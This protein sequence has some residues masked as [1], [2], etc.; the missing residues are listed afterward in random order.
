MRDPVFGRVYIVRSTTAIDGRANQL[1]F[2]V[3]IGIAGIEIGKPARPLKIRGSRGIA[4]SEKVEVGVRF[5]VMHP[6]IVGVKFVVDLAVLSEL[7][8]DAV[9]HLLRDRF[10][11][12]WASEPHSTAGNCRSSHTH[13]RIRPFRATHRAR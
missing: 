12:L 3:V 2:G 11:L 4:Q 10:D 6:V 5:A 7:R 13:R 9:P 8:G 1:L